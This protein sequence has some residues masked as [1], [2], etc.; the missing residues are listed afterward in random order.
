MV[1]YRGIRAKSPRES[2]PSWR[3]LGYVGT[4]I[5]PP[6]TKHT[7]IY[8]QIPLPVMPSRKKVFFSTVH[9]RRK[10]HAY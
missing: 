8:L 6:S 2:L 5:Q 10:T 3:L 9:I 4:S 1:S 7:R